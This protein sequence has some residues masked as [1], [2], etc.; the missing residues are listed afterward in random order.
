M[1]KTEDEDEGIEE[2][3][4]LKLKKL[5]EHTTPEPTNQP[6]LEDPPEPSHQLTDLAQP[7]TKDNIFKWN[8]MKNNY[9]SIATTWHTN[10]HPNQEIN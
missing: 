1:N 2:N 6:P 5:Q 7:S 3:N 10:T 8:Q 4:E 9:W